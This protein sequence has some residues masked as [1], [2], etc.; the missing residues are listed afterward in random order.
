MT[1]E[2][3]KS[4]IDAMAASDLAEMEF[5][6]DGWS[7]RLVR[8]KGPEAAAA[9]MQAAP[10][11]RAPAPAAAPRQ[12]AAP[13]TANDLRSPM[14]GVVYLAP[15]PGAA[16]FVTPGQAVTAGTTVCMVEAMKVFQEI[17]AGRDGV[18]EAVAVTSG[19]EVEAGQV[20]ARF[21]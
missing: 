1:P 10:R 16:P 6:E 13:P 21:A 5:S 12:K 11:P 2:T 9:T 20:L 18:I 14:F 3:I 17:K 4:L 15:S 7:L 8:H 19:E